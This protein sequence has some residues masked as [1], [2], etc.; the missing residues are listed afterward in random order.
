MMMNEK[1]GKPNEENMMT[2]FIIVVTLVS[3][4]AM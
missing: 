4:R 1:L 2:V 3:G